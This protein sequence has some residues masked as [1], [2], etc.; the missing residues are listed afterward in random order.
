MTAPQVI[1]R[2]VVAG[3]ATVA[4]VLLLIPGLGCS[5]L[6]NVN[7]YHVPPAAVMAGERLK[8][9]LGFH[10]RGF[11]DGTAQEQ[12]RGAVLCH[13]SINGQ[14]YQAVEMSQVK[15]SN[16]EVW[17]SVEIDI[18]ETAELIEYY[19]VHEIKGAVG[20]QS[21]ANQKYPYRSEIASE[22]NAQNDP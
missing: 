15:H 9:E 12:I 7:A 22:R 3:L 2:S 20:A 11:I 13:Y 4:S 6:S 14:A 21:I 1:P 10:F 18:P 5:N 19:F 16:M 8:L 17:Y